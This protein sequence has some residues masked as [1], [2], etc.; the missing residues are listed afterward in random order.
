MKYQLSFFIVEGF[1]FSRTRLCYFEDACNRMT[2][3]SNDF[4]YSARYQD[5]EY[6][7]RHVHIT[8]EVGVEVSN[9]MK[10]PNLQFMDEVSFLVNEG[11]FYRYLISSDHI[12]NFYIKVNPL[13]LLIIRSSDFFNTR[14]VSWK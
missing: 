9:V 1:I 3:G 6:E 13:L 14:T 4:Y 10:I 8:R 7:Y 5:D 2:T 12:Q 11:I